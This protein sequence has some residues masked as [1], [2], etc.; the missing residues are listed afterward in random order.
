MD[1]NASAVAVAIASAIA[2]GGG[3]ANA[4]AVALA[5]AYHGTEVVRLNLRWRGILIIRHCVIYSLNSTAHSTYHHT[6]RK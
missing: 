4:T 2:Q 1:F 3:T 5:E 6:H